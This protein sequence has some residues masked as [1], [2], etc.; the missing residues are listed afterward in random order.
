MNSDTQPHNP[1]IPLSGSASEMARRATS[2]V[3]E[4]AE[5]VSNAGK[6]VMHDLENAADDV[7]HAT[8]DAVKCC[9]DK[10]KEIYQTAVV[11]AD[12]TLVASKDF[13]RRNPVP[14]VLGAIAFGAA[15]GY[16]LLMPRRK[17]SFGEHYQNEPL[18]AVR[19]AFLGAIAPVTNRVHQGYDN[20]RDS[21]GKAI[22]RVHD[23]GTGRCRNSLSGQVERIGHNLKFW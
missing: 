18:T 8:K 15:V 21:A 2:A 1:M 9:S 3:K 13:I 6:D 4:T 17:M 10:A 16:V 12:D 23:Y 11:K 5:I 20:A 19:Q 22:N 14:V 7:T